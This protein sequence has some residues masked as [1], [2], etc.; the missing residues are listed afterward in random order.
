MGSSHRPSRAFG[1]LRVS[2]DSQADSGLGLDAQRD[3]IDKTA[4]RLGLPVAAVFVDAGVSGARDLENRPQLFAAVQGLKRGDVL[5]VAK[6]DRLGRDLIKVALIERDIMAKSA[7][8]VSAAGEGGEGTD[9]SAVLQRHII[10]AFGQYE[11][12]L[13]AQRTRAALRAKRARGE[14]AGTVPF[15]H[16]L[17]ADGQKLEPCPTEQEVLALV[18]ELR[19][20]AFSQRAI[21]AEL[22]RRNYRT[23]AGGAWAHQ[24]VARL[25]SRI[26]P[27]ADG[28]PAAA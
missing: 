28:V 15:G 26:T 9:A 12:S 19:N 3:A 6:R 4:A 24:Y 22:N 23:R 8:I 1:Y 14:R 17:G 13:I 25:M 11:R 20:A 18:A 16:Q 5:I 2:T 27:L 7:R 21:A 10:D